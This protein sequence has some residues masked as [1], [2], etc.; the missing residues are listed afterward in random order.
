MHIYL[1]Q[2]L[3]YK[4]C[5]TVTGVIRQV[6]IEPDGDSHALLLLDA[7]YTQMLTTQNYQKQQ[8]YLV[9]ED[10]CHA[11]PKDAL[12]YFVCSNYVSQLPN[13][14]LG[15]RYEITGNYVIDDWHG[16]WAEI[17]GVSELKSL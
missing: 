2:R 16:S 17:H 7:P 3:D 14:E 1:P 6:K 9:I 15:K 13:P 12:A 5:R 4:G 11:K 8:G 10:T